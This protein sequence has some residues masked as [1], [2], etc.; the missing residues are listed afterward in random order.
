MILLND[1]K[2]VIVYL[3]C[4]LAWEHDPV[5]KTQADDQNEDSQYAND[6]IFGEKI[7]MELLEFGEV[8]GWLLFDW[9]YLLHVGSL[10]LKNIFVFLFIL[11]AFHDGSGVFISEYYGIQLKN[12]QRILTL[13]LEKD[14]NIYCRSFAGFGLLLFPL[15][16][17]FQIY[18]Y[19]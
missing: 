19:Y 3:F 5:W 12:D 1:Q 4:G 14:I 11:E 6:E 13:T 7:K 16:V 2:S 15:P 8:E 18:Y 17:S 9:F 10:F